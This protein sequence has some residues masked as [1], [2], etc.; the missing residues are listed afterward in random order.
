MDHRLHVY[1]PADGPALELYRD[2]AEI[3]IVPYQRLFMPRSPV[4]LA[5][6]ATDFLR[7]VVR[8]RRLFRTHGVETVISATTA[9]PAATLA[10]R[11][12][13]VAS[14]IYCGELFDD[15]SASRARRLAARVM[16][17]LVPRSADLV[18]CS[19]DRTASQF[20]GG[21]RASIVRL[22]PPIERAAAA[23]D[24]SEVR[25]A[26]G[27]P[28]GRPVVVIVG[29]LSP[30]R[31]QDVAIS[32]L[33]I[34]RTRGKHP[35]LAIAGETGDG[36]GDGEYVEDLARLVASAGLESDVRFLGPVTDIASLLV[37]ADVFVNPARV[38]ESFGR[39]AFEALA[40]G[41][42][43]VVTRTGAQ[44]ELLRD[45]ISALIVPP[46]D[47]AAIASALERVLDSPALAERLVRGATESLRMLDPDLDR[48]R[49]T[50][51]LDE[52]VSG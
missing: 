17:A 10:A 30:G 26:F 46:G 31:G 45:E 12:L 20:A 41:V 43:A 35:V 42:P 1:A 32:A 19:S 13:G 51:L 25:R 21:G 18:I 24:A 52:A 29:M 47:P 34:L 44:T 5:R 14:I 7:D 15:A 23:R 50:R 27:F 39:V 8:F 22:Y 36:P 11:T 16:T 2:F 28:A 49:F 40:H 4:G 38:A 48:V 33:R 37:A 3:H 6:A 9:T